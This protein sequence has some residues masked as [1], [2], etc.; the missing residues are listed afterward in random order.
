M[1]YNEEEIK[2]INEKIASIEATIQGLRLQQTNL[3]LVL[4]MV[5]YKNCC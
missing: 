2:D 3:N 1:R 4:Q 5:K